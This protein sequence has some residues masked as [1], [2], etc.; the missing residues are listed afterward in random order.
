M[1]LVD[2]AYGIDDNTTR[3]SWQLLLRGGLRGCQGGVLKSFITT[4]PAKYDRG[5]VRSVGQYPLF[6][7]VSA[8]GFHAAFRSASQS[9]LA[10]LRFDM[11]TRPEC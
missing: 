6:V 4:P 7:G 3:G 2:A 1:P 10:S 5:K 9:I 8:G 11:I